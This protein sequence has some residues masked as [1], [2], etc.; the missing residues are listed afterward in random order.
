MQKITSFFSHITLCWAYLWKQWQ[1]RRKE[2]DRLFC[3]A[4]S[5][6]TELR[7][8][9][10][11]P[12]G[13]WSVSF[14][15]VLKPVEMV[16][17]YV[18]KDSF[19]RHL[20]WGCFWSHNK[21]RKHLENTKKPSL[22]G[23]AANTCTVLSLWG[24]PQHQWKSPYLWYGNRSTMASE[25]CTTPPGVLDQYCTHGDGTDLTMSLQKPLAK[26]EDDQAASSPRHPQG[27]SALRGSVF[28]LLI[29]S[30]VK[31]LRDGQPALR[32]G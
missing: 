30:P 19:W 8:D 5:L 20:P 13:D 29:S 25:L 11:G 18:I 23:N 4:S 1:R 14:T 3:L 7:G 17:G 31:T 2:R 28:G 22:C 26:W 24:K 6:L 21:P 16:P 15:A 9:A 27:I 12:T 10:S 32:S